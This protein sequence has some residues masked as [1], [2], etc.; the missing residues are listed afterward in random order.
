MSVGYPENKL[1]KSN[2][3]LVDQKYAKLFFS[4]MPFSKNLLPVGSAKL[5]S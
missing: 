3:K 1:Q 5:Y 4:W 2:E